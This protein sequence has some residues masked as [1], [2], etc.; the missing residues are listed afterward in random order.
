MYCF[1]CIDINLY[2]FDRHIYPNKNLSKNDGIS[3]HVLGQ[4]LIED[5][6]LKLR[7]PCSIFS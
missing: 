3:I 1:L 4:A 5:E 6:F 2:F 7:A